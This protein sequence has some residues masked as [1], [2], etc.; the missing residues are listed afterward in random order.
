MDWKLAL[1]L[2]V[3]AVVVVAGWFLAHWLTARRELAS[4]RREARVKALEAA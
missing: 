3:P 1:S 4:K 2:G